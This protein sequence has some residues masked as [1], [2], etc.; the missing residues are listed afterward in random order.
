MKGLFYLLF[1][2]DAKYT[3]ILFL[4]FLLIV[5]VLYTLNVDSFGWDGS[6]YYG[7]A[8]NIRD[9]FRFTTNLSLYHQGMN[10]LPHPT[11][12]YPLWP[13]LL[14][15]V[16]HL[17]PLEV[18]ARVLP[19]LFYFGSIII[20]YSL[21]QKNLPDN[22]VKTKYFVVNYSHLGVFI[23]FLHGQYFVAT[24]NPYTEA[25]A[26]FLLLICLTRLA[27]IMRSDRM[28]TFIEIGVWSAVLLLV[29][30][31]LVVFFMSVIFFY[32]LVLF[33]S[34]NIKYLAGI[35][36]LIVSFF[37][38]YSPQLI[39][40]S[41][42]FGQINPA[43][44][45][46]FDQYQASNLLSKLHVLMRYETFVEFLYYKIYGL[47]VAFLPWGKYSYSMT[48]HGFQY[49]LIGA[50]LLACITYS[51]KKNRDILH[52]EISDLL[53][54]PEKKFF[55]FFLIFSLAFFCS[56][57]ML[58]KT[59]WATWNFPTRHALVCS[60]IFF[61]GFLYLFK[62]TLCPTVRKL[63]L[64]IFLLA[65]SIGVGNLVVQTMNQVYSSKF[66]KKKDGSDSLV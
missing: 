8:R 14:G 18:V 62:Q 36:M 66:S 58:H 6:Y 64:F 52:K 3:N 19:I 31:Q 17:F 2:S 61:L 63:A 1:R 33:S 13:Y 15:Y 10:Y 11:P 65:T 28:A 39:F 42:K 37:I 12:V 47:G 4:S 29:R 27:R 53:F 9:T 25:M 55:L 30:S 32:L 22:I 56:I 21:I 7:I 59:L 49:S 43:T 38:T 20:A 45:L 5:K 44:I 23:F 54:Q 34:R 24:S 35:F 57:Q 51:S 48:F 50:S 46:F 16:S 26:Y 41:K 40:L 60:F